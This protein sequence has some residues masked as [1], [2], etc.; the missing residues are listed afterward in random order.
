M[1]ALRLLLAG[2]AVAAV[3]AVRTGA[4]DRQKDDPA[5]AEKTARERALIDLQLR[6][7]EAEAAARAAQAAAERAAA[8]GQQARQGKDAQKDDVRRAQ[9]AQAQLLQ[10]RLAAEAQQRAVIDAR[11]AEALIVR[12]QVAGRQVWP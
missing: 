4:Q 7:V 1:N 3:F 2:L 6:Q 8:A 10:L 11:A 5:R 9:E 12:G